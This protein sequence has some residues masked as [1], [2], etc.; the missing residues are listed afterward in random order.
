MDWGIEDPRNSSFK[1]VL[2]QIKDLDRNFDL[3]FCDLI[4]YVNN[5]N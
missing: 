4:F 3:V 1:G 2:I 5:I